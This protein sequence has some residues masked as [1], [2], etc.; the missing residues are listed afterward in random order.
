MVPSPAQPDAIIRTRSIVKE[1]P[2]VRALDGVSFDVRP[3]EIHALVGENGA[4]KSTLIRTLTGEHPHGSFSGDILLRGAPVRFRSVRDSQHA[5]IAAVHQELA[6][7][8]H[9]TVGENILLGDEPLRFGLF[10]W[11]RMFR[12]ADATLKRLGVSLDVRTE[13]VNLGMGEQQLVEIA[14][15]IHKD[16]PVLILDEPTAAL[17]DHEVDTLMAILRDLRGQGIGLIYISHKLD[18]VLELADRIT[19]LRDGRTIATDDAANWTRDALVQ[20]MVGRTTAEFYVKTPGAPGDVALEVDSLCL[21]DPELPG[22][23][24]L[25]DVSF[26]V[27]KGEILGIA[28]LMGAGRT[29][30]LATVFGAAPGLWRGAIRVNGCEVRIRTPRDAIEAGL[31]LVPEDRKRHGLNLLFSVLQ[32]L[33]MAHLSEFCE[34]GV[35]DGHRE[36]GECRAAARELDVRTTS[37]HAPAQTLSG[38]NQQKV[39]LGKWLLRRPQVLFLDEP[40]RGIDV[41]AKAEIHRL[42]GELTRDGMAVVMASSELPEVLNVSDRIL[43][44][45]EGRVTGEFPAAEATAERIMKV[46]T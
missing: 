11:D 35:V 28:G 13:V 34:V 2:G 12:E 29:E 10:D 41:G 27:R 15:A 32:N 16:R 45:R 14:R 6:L 9:L 25:E 5:G 30:L 4:G 39:V 46:A 33:S 37:M 21:E 23:L 19:V 40:T 17:A 24:L 20:A 44:L 36:Y 31:A 26:A 42:I 1:F 3:G 18:E 8:K 7:V 38:G 43:V 22:R